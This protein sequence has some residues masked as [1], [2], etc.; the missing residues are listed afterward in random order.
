MA[1]GGLRGCR[2]L[3][4][5]DEFILAEEL[6][7]ELAEAGAVVIGPAPSLER[8][9]ELV[10]APDDVDIAVLDV[11]LRGNPVYPI[12]DSLLE[13]HVPFVFTTGYDVSALPARFTAVHCC[14]KPVDMPLLLEALQIAIDTSR[15]K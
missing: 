14:T 3:V 13:R 9:I 8:A 4:V 12:A 15:R 10:A 1:E 6:S 11:N 7:Q 2:V 5:E